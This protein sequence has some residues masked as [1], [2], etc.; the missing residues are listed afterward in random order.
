MPMMNDETSERLRIRQAARGTACSGITRKNYEVQL[1]KN[2]TVTSH[3]I[4]LSCKQANLDFKISLKVV[5]VSGICD[6]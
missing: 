2:I 1:L 4:V 6:M 3:F 5:L